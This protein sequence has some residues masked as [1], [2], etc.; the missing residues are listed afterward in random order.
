MFEKKIIPFRYK[1]DRNHVLDLYQKRPYSLEERRG[2][3]PLSSR[4]EK[5]VPNT[6]I[7]SRSG[8]E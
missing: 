6:T 3:L 8:S 4:V 7:L 5:I 2:C 1:K